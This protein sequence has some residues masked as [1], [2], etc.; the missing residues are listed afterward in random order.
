MRIFVGILV[1]SAVVLL[2]GSA[3]AQSKK[4]QPRQELLWPD[5]APGALGSEEA[6]RPALT[7]YDVVFTSKSKVFRKNIGASDF[8]QKKLIATTI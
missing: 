5:G 3:F 4:T 8:Y 6:D 7:I 2:G 1:L